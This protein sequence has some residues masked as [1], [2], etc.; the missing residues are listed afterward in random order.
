MAV[1][2]GELLELSLSGGILGFLDD[3]QL[4]QA[5]NEELCRAAEKL[6]RLRGALEAELAS[7]LGEIDKREA[8]EKDG[9]RSLAEWS[10]TRLKVSPAQGKKLQTRASRLSVLPALHREL[11]LGNL[12]TEQLDPLLQVARPTTDEALASKAP[13]WSVAQCNRYARHTKLLRASRGQDPLAQE[14]QRYFSMRQMSDGSWSM[15]GRL[16]EESGSIVSNALSQLAQESG[17]NEDTGHYDSWPERMADAL[18]DLVSAGSQAVAPGLPSIMVHVDASVLSGER[19]GTGELEGAK[20]GT[21]LLSKEATERLACD[22]LWQVLTKDDKGTPVNL[23][24]RYR[25]APH[26]LRSLLLRRDGGCRFPGCQAV[27]FLHAHH[28]AHWSKGGE[29]DPNNMILICSRHHKFLHE[30]HWQVQGAPDE[31]MI[32]TSPDGD[33]LESAPVPRPEDIEPGEEVTP[34]D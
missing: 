8:Y 15:S 27:R 10:V 31:K 26:W 33:Y 14:P 24:R 2:K 4:A 1:V 17:P 25:S 34:P 11:A 5:S 7:V 18:I 22:A 21:G 19:P 30:K 23:G 3:A 32:F 20:D 13:S 12:T 29:T 9:A 16:E 28:L 6:Q